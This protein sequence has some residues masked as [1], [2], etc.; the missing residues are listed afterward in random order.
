MDFNR[1]R[2]YH[3]D[4]VKPG[5]LGNV[6]VFN[7]LD[8]STLRRDTLGVQYARMPN[9]SGANLQMSDCLLVDS[10]TDLSHEV[11]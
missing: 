1:N 5:C 7:I 3:M 11:Q 2:C 8:T 6:H 10:R 4:V 9:A